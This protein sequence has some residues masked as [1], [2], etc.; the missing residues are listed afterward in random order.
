MVFALTFVILLLFQPLLKKFGPQQPA[1]PPKTEQQ[2]AA[3]PP[4]A[5]AQISAAP[6]APVKGGKPAAAAPVNTKQAESEAETVVESELYK[7]TFTNR[8]AQV[9][10]WILKKFSDDK[11]Q[12]LDL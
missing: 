12:P 1:T 9:K 3:P 7:V 11:G 10:S 6:V 2:Q 5:P 8:G 4:A